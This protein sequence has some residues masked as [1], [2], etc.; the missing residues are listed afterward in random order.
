MRPYQLTK[1]F[2]TSC[3]VF[4]MLVLFIAYSGPSFVIVITVCALVLS[5]AN[6]RGTIIAYKNTTVVKYWEDNEEDK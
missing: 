3:L 6:L 1:D 5:L 2:L 4:I